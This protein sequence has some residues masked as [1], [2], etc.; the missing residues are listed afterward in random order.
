MLFVDGRY[1]LQ[2][3]EQVDTVAVRDRAPGRDAA[4]TTGSSR[5]SQPATASATTRGCT[6]ST[7]PS[8]SPRPAPPPA[9]TLVAGRAQS[10]RRDL[11]RPP[12]AAARPGHAARPALR[13]RG[14]RRQARAHPRRDREAARPTRWWSRDPHAVAWTFNIR[15]SRRAAHAA[16]ARLRHRAARGPPVALC[17]RPQAR[18][19]RAPSARRARRRA[20]ARRLRARR[21]PRS[22]RPSKT[23][24]LDQATA[25]DALARLVDRPP[26]ARSRA[27]PIRS[28]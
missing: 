11:D 21:S 25:A 27:A 14:R 16:A 26:A 24:R 17:R 18:E 8:G 20:R 7:A 13:R 2:A 28:R 9:P 19:R 22:A 1:T 3:R 23:V 6:P 5:T 15:G 12:G 10:D 4:A